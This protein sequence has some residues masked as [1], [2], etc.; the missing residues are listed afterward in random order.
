MHVARFYPRALSPTFSTPSAR[1]SSPTPETPLAP[2]VLPLTKPTPNRLPLMP[3][4]VLDEE[5]GYGMGATMED[6]VTHDDVE[7]YEGGWAN[8]WPLGV[9]WCGG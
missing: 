3:P 2:I 5:D 6:Y 4:G 9:V 8:T 1:S 7:G